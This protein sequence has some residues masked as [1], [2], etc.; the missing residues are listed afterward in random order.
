MDK[1]WTQSK[2]LDN[3]RGRFIEIFHANPCKISGV[4]KTHKVDNP[5]RM[6]AS[7]CGAAIENLSIFV[8]KCLGS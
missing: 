4:I 1:K 5:V 3:T 6:I 2:V 8:E 7:G